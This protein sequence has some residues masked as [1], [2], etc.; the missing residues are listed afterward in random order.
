MTTRIQPGLHREIKRFGATGIDT[1]MNCGNCTAVCSLAAEG[2]SFPGRIV[3]LLQ[4]GNRERLLHSLGMWL[5]HYCGDCSTSCPRDAEPGEITMATRRYLTAQ[6]DWMGQGR[7]FYVSKKWLIAAMDIVAAIVVAMFVLLHGPVVTDHVALN[8]FAPVHVIEMTDWI[9]GGILAL[10]LLANAGR[11]WRFVT[12]DSPRPA[13][14]LLLSEARTL[15]L[16][17]F[18]QKR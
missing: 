14:R 10:L 11:M 12:A 3:H 15:L 7:K 5:C 2:E 9:G 1:C 13:L 8:T 4:V 6:Y 18:T 16:H 17:F